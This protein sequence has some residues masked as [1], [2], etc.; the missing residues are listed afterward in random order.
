VKAFGVAA[1][2]LEE[3]PPEARALGEEIYALLEVLDEEE[4]AEVAAAIESGDLEDGPW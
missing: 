3:G 2:W 1:E 4:L